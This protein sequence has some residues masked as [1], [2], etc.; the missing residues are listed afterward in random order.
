MNIHTRLLPLAAALLAALPAAAQKAPPVDFHG[1][2]RAGVGA[3]GGG[4]DQAC[5]QLAGATKKYRLGNECEAYGELE[6]DAT[7]H[8]TPGGS[9]FKIGTMLALVMPNHSD[10]ESD[11]VTLNW[12]EAFVAVEKM[13]EGAFADATLWAGKRYYDRH[14]VHINDFYF[15][16]NSG[17]GAGIEDINVGLGKLSY[18]LRRNGEKSETVSAER[19]QLL[20]H[21]IR[22]KDIPVNPEGAL[23]VGLD[24]RHRHS[25]KGVKNPGGQGL[26]V[27]HTQKGLFNGGYNKAAL[28]FGK[29]ALSNLDH[30]FPSFD[31]DKSDKSWR[32]VESLVWQPGN[33]SRWSGMATL[34]YEDRDLTGSYD[35]GDSKSGRWISFG[36][37]PVY[38]FTDRWSL[39]SE[40]GLDQFKP[41]DGANRKLTKLTV[42]AQYGSGA[43]F[44]ARPVIRAFWTH[45]RWNRAGQDAAK[46]GETLS[47]TGIFG[48]SRKGNTFGVQAEV[49]W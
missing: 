37:R 45:A 5:F 14:D 38:H 36:V 30:S 40:L 13:G 10:W 49:W 41:E 32:L 3:S 46:A 6:L 24:L 7:V 26:T 21:D 9:R 33:G 19:R 39:A 28:Q 12:R 18:A 44:W 48:S 20:G 4:G 47:D 15:W 23:T 11:N 34:V 25:D 2:F 43:N 31:A 17:P 29:G 35:N 16:S 8:E 42:A 22:W 27:M 1:Y